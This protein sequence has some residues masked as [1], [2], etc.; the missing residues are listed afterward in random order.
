MGQVSL[1]TN[2]VCLNPLAHSSRDLREQSPSIHKVN[3]WQYPKPF[4]AG[5]KNLQEKT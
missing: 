3:V 2:I 5:R 4:L 1:I